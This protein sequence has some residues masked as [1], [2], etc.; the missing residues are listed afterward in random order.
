VPAGAIDSAEAIE[1]DLPLIGDGCIGRR[2]RPEEAVDELGLGGVVLASVQPDVQTRWFLGIVVFRQ[3]DAIREHRAVDLGIVGMD[4]FLAL[5][6][7][8]LVALDLF[9]AFNPLVQ[10]HQ[11]MIDS[12][13]D[14]EHVRELE[15]HSPGFRIDFYVAQQFRIRMFGSEIFH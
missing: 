13:L 2:P 11:R 1:L 3:R 14:S 5:M 7:S 9:G 12:G 4:L 6:P 10:N 8:R 15:E